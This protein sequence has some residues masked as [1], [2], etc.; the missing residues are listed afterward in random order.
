MHYAR[1]ATHLCLPCWTHSDKRKKMP[2]CLILQ[3]VN[4]VLSGTGAVHTRLS[5]GNVVTRHFPVNSTSIAVR[6]NS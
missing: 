4:I 6:Y 3:E 5:D 2:P 1:H